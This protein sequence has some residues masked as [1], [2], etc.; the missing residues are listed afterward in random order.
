MCLFVSLRNSIK[1][2]MCV[3][4]CVCVCVRACV[5]GV[6]CD[7]LFIVCVLCSVACDLSHI[8]VIFVMKM[9]TKT[10]I[11]WHQIET[12]TTRIIDIERIKQNKSRTS[13]KKDK[14]KSELFR[15]KIRNIDNNFYFHLVRCAV[16]VT[17]DIHYF[18][19][20]APVA[21]DLI[22][23]SCDVALQCHCCGCPC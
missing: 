19:F 23:C 8:R 9:E 2:C 1:T 11:I 18:N 21:E 7:A 22:H 10:S 3:R 5:L 13:G 17:V 4:V 15:C 20:L 14:R 12:T 16:R 6:G